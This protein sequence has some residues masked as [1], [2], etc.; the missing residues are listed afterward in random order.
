MQAL[1]KRFPA[2][3]LR[4]AR[5][6]RNPGTRS[7]TAKSLTDKGFFDIVNHIRELPAPC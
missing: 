5:W 4:A 6:A 2:A 1:P 7:Q 3:R